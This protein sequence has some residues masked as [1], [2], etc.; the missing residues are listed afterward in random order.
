VAKQK[1]QGPRATALGQ[2]KTNRGQVGVCRT[3]GRVLGYA[4]H[5]NID[6]DLRLHHERDHCAAA[7]IAYRAARNADRVDF[8][9]GE[10]PTPK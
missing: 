6:L 4:G 2:T 3:C 9:P 7:G 10:E 8:E 5:V 1:Y